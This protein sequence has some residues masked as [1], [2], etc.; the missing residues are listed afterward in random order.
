L[1]RSTVTWDT[2]SYAFGDAGKACAQLGMY[3]TEITTAT[4][5]LWVMGS[6]TRPSSI[7]LGA[8]RPNPTSW[9][10]WNKTNTV[11]SYSN[12]PM[13]QP[14]NA[15]R[16]CLSVAPWNNWVE[17][18]CNTVLDYVSCE[19]DTL[20]SATGIM[21]AGSRAWDLSAANAAIN[22]ALKDKTLIESWATQGLV[23]LGGTA[24]D[25]AADL[26]KQL[27]FWGPIVKRIGFTAES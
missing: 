9:F 22:A 26:K 24:E 10:V 16:L 2:Q 21:A 14:S 20:A 13:F 15:S 5:Q 17:V 3:A 12:F 18:S 19:G 11:A 23:P 4:E 1:V 27:A 6:W 8:K 7:Y 25:M